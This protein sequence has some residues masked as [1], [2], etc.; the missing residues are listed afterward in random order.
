MQGVKCDVL[1]CGGCCRCYNFIVWWLI[2][3]GFFLVVL[4]LY[5]LSCGRFGSGLVGSLFSSVNMC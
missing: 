2:L 3:F 5:V 1:L 4:L